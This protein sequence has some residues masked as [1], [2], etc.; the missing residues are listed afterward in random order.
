M[1]KGVAG[2]TIHMVLAGMLRVLGFHST[3]TMDDN[4]TKRE[5]L[6]VLYCKA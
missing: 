4:K 6:N 5:S 1:P 3:L 2:Y